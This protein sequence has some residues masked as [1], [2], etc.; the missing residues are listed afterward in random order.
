MNLEG[1]FSGTL[2]PIYTFF[3]V[4]AMFSGGWVLLRTKGGL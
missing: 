2:G 1:I 4:M 3:A